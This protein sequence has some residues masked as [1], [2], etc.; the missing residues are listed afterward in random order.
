MEIYKVMEGLKYTFGEDDIKKKWQV[1]QNP[2]D[3]V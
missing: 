2:K 3:I 1:Y